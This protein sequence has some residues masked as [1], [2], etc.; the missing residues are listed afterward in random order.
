MV[1]RQLN[2]QPLCN[3]LMCSFQVYSKWLVQT[4]KPTSLHTDLCNAVTTCWAYSGSH[5]LLLVLSGPPDTHVGRHTF[6]HWQNVMI[7]IM[8]TRCF[9]TAFTT[10]LVLFEAEEDGHDC[11]YA[12]NP[13][14]S[15]PDY[16]LQ[17]SRPPR[18]IWSWASNVIFHCKSVLHSSV[19]H[20]YMFWNYCAIY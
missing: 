5:Q 6:S 12:W 3:Y 7:M 20:G 18:E 19:V 14:V 11:W 15:F 17:L 9:L 8:K 2:A 10:A 16:L 1:F 13:V 4:N